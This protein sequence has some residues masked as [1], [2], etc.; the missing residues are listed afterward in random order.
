M[1]FKVFFLFLLAFSATTQSS[2]AHGDHGHNDIGHFVDFYERIIDFNES[3]LMERMNSRFAQ[4]HLRV[5]RLN[6]P[7]NSEFWNLLRLWAEVYETEL[8]RDGC[9]HCEVDEEAMVAKAKDL[10]AKG[11]LKDR[12]YPYFK[13]K[14]QDISMEAVHVGAPLGDFFLTAKALAEVVESIGSVTVGG[15][16]IHV[17]CTLIDAA[18]IFGARYMQTSLRIPM[19]SINT[20]TGYI[21]PSVKAAYVS[22][23]I[24]KAFKRVRFEVAPFELNLTKEEKK[25]L[26]KEKSKVHSR[27]IKWLDWLERK[28]HDLVKIDAKSYFGKRY[29]RFMF[30]IRRR[31]I[32]YLKGD[33]V[34]DTVFAKKHIWSLSVETEPFKYDFVQ[35]K[36]ETSNL[37]RVKSSTI[38][39]DELVEAILEDNQLGGSSLARRLVSDI[40]FIFDSNNTYRERYARLV[41]I[42]SAYVGF[43]YELN[44]K[45]FKKKYEQS[46]QSSFKRILYYQYK[47]GKVVSYLYELMDLLRV[48]S[49][50]K[51][52]NTLQ[53]Y[54]Y[55]AIESFARVIRL[56]TVIKNVNLDDEDSISSAVYE[57]NN[58]KTF[59]P[60]KEKNKRPKILPFNFKY[61]MCEKM[62]E[63]KVEKG[64]C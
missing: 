25:R 48:M 16:G 34:V 60:W 20:G 28:G 51:D 49:V 32:R 40:E 14:A 41:M 33:G 37:F 39:K 5:G 3:H 52:S 36:G 56:N 35:A 18:L 19:N 31:N 1:I 26:K 50:T 57:L 54:K 62:W 6:I 47:L 43:M 61:P 9:S 53:K 24:R 11:L 4:S 38:K 59:T 2:F 10:H 42:E 44:S 23:T 55:E 58:L 64:C 46:L 27:H 17:F 15:K 45:L 29:K 30:L 22:H 63:V 21:L 7:L 12:I 8:Q 13:E